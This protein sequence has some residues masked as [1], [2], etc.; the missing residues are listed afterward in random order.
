MPIIANLDTKNRVEI[1]AIVAI[2]YIVDKLLI[3]A[4]ADIRIKY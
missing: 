2:I 3:I 1:I 4:I